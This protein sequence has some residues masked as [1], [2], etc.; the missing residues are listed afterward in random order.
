[1]PKS[2]FL[3]EF[4]PFFL[5]F[6]RVIGFMLSMPFL[7]QVE[8]SPRFRVLAGLAFSFLLAPALPTG[9]V[10]VTMSYVSLAVLC[11]HELFI[12]YFVGLVG[13][14]LLTILDCA[15]M[16]MSA[17]M[18]LSSA[19]IF[20]PNFSGQGALTSM[21]MVLFGIAVFLS[22]DL[23]HL[24][25]R[26]LVKSY[27][28]FPIDGKLMLGDMSK[29]YSQLFSLIF[30]MGLQLSMPFII[31]FIVLQVG[32]GLMNRMIPQM[33]IFFV[34]LPLQIWGGLMVFLITGGSIIMRFSSIFD[35]E[36]RAFFTLG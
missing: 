29:G 26:G 9:T 24:M 33:Q 31:V 22:L 18:G 5:V 13:R 17:Q 4:I 10:D 15:G 30:S 32:F 35:R 19:T 2:L 6:C 11:A 21:I 1:M 12:G 20:N 16:M 28:L 27:Y 7:G 8:V 23:H 25:F 36:Y 34:S 14:L 3:S